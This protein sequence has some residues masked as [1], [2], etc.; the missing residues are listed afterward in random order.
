M[1][2]RDQMVQVFIN[3]LL[4]AISIVAP[5]TG[6][7]SLASFKNESTAPVII[8]KDN[9]P[10]IPEEKVDHIFDPFFSMSGTGTGLGLSIVYTLLAQNNARIKVSSRVGNGTQFQLTFKEYHDREPGDG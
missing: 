2:D 7:I 1:A 9:G 8:I 4:N 10:G 6:I 3:L 5:G